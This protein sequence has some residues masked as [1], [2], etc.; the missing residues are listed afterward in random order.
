MSRIIS[1]AES[2]EAVYTAF[3]NINF[4]AFDFNTIKQSLLEYIKLTFPETFNDY[5][6]SSE[7]IA[8]IES[9][10][11][12][13]ELLAYRVD[14]NAHENFISTAER[15]DSVLRLA[16]LVSYTAA[17]PL[18]ARGLVKLA[19]VAT[20]ETVIDAN[21]IDLANQVIRWNDSSNTSWK[22]Q[23]ILIMNRV[24]DQQFGSVS[25]FDRFQLQDVLFELYGV[26]LAPLPRG[27]FQYGVVV[28][29]AS[30]PM[31][32]VPISRDDTYGIIE[33]RPENNSNFTLLYGSDGNGDSS[34]TTGFF[35]YT[36]QGTLQRFSTEFDGITPNQV[37]ELN[38]TQINDTDIWVNGVDPVTREIVDVAPDF[39]FRVKDGRSGEWKQVDLA[40]AQNIIFNTNPNRNKYEVETR[41]ENRVRIIFGDGEFA[42][43]PSGT[44]EIWARSSV[45]EDV[46]IPQS[47]V[48]NVPTSFTYTDSFGR[49]QTFSFTFTLINSLQN[50]SASEDTE[51][52]RNTAPAVYYTQDRMV[53]GEDYN[54]FMLQDPS[55]M[56]LRAVNRTFAGDS[57]YIPWHDNSESYENVKMFGDD[58]CL[59]YETKDVAETTPVVDINTLI[60]GYV[61]PLLSSPDV[62]L[63]LVSNGV[64]YGDIRRTFTAEEKDQLSTAMYPPPADVYLYYDKISNDW[65]SSINPSVVPTLPPPGASSVLAGTFVTGVQY[66]ITTLGT[67]DYTL[68][69]AGGNTVGETFVATGPGAG[70]GTATPYNY[71]PYY[72]IRVEQPSALEEVYD[73]HRYAKR[74]IV[75]SRTTQFWNTNSANRVIDYDTS[76]SVFDQIVVLKANSN[77][78]RDGILSQNWKFNVLGQEM[79]TASLPDIHRL[80]VLPYDE[81]GDGVPDNLD[82]NDITNP[83][84]IAEIFT[85]KMYFDGGIAS[86]DIILPISYVDAGD[87]TVTQVLNGTPVPF[88]TSFDVNHI[89]TT[90][91]ITS[92]VVG[93]DVVVKV[94]EYV[95]FYRPTVTDDWIA[96]QTT[97]Q[98]LQNFYDDSLLPDNH[99]WRRF[100]GKDQLNF[101]WF[102]YSPRY[103]LVDP[104]PS[105]II[106]AFVITKGYYIA[107][108]RWLEDPIAP[109]PRPPTALDLRT[110]YA[111]L[112]DNK[113]ISD[114]VILHPGNIKLL[115]GS[116]AMPESRATLRIVKSPN[117]ILTDNQIKTS[118]VTTV[119][120]FF[121]ITQWE[122]GETF[123]FTELAAAIHLSLPS[124]I[125][126]V[127]LVPDLANNQ[128]GDMFQVIAREDEIFYPDITVDDVEIVVS[129]T[130]TNM[131]QN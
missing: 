42:D 13:A 54:I 88:T 1:R 34:D 78:T 91:N 94:R 46:V 90:I 82:P 15:R 59:Y 8:I 43:I 106:D 32:L 25:P 84:G 100:E 5:I 119:R 73:V 117:S 74:L 120:N 63:Q 123:Y 107:L 121:D 17:R 93:V 7:F 55:I 50:A 85:P 24:L 129:L 115:F 71:I 40:H 3:Q 99:L 22:E 57:K 18:P 49:T 114:T 108:Q 4:A 105:N 66:S 51:H 27:V 111:Y 103:H 35:C 56:K 65:Y 130:S 20:T 31:E 110:S 26:N 47:S 37:F 127:V 9:F 97:Y 14:M 2:W 76:V 98:V 86:G 69:G 12:I 131:K 52:I 122:F 30:L 72:I 116:R 21:G 128:F 70:T 53:N 23:F 60:D 29:G 62:I 92:P 81:N 44:F 96:V 101:S 48:V 125:S 45:D 75:E 109:K 68:I 64:A 39:S 10:A 126:T 104:S 6:E 80:S 124:D 38:A 83:Q 41:D 33:R 87:I 102:H 36:K 11:Y 89:G 118:V 77:H 58:A 79:T 16:K 113:M 61:E 28:N 95:Y 19:S 112:L 67:T